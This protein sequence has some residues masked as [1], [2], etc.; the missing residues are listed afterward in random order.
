MISSAARSTSCLVVLPCCAR[1]A[2][3][4]CP[5]KSPGDIA[6]PRNWSTGPVWYCSHMS[7]RLTD[8][9]SAACLH[10]L[11]ALN[12]PLALTSCR[13]V[14]V[15]ASG[16]LETCARALGACEPNCTDRPARL[17]FMLEA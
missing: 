11:Q 5:V 2:V 15:L 4:H 7:A 16:V 8:I 10:V 14:I 13:S 17:F 9:K 6:V 12:V 1:S 3:R